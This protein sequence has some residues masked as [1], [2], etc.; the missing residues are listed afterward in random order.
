MRPL[1]NRAHDLLTEQ[2]D[3]NARYQNSSARVLALYGQLD[4]GAIWN[5]TFY[6]LVEWQLWVPAP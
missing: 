3:L 4:A 2:G 1:L 5:R 6:E